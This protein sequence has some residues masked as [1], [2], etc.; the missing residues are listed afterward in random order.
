MP[1]RH[2]LIST[3]TGTFPTTGANQPPFVDFGKVGWA[4]SFTGPSTANKDYAG[5]VQGTIGDSANWQTILTLT[6]SN[7][8]DQVN[9]VNIASTGDVVLFDKARIVLTK[10]NTTA[11]TPVWLALLD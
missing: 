5:T 3:A 11:S 10:N 8:T 7:T 6:T 4:L 2:I 1:I 9:T